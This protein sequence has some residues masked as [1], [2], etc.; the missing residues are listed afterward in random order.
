MDLLELV[1]MWLATGFTC[2]PRMEVQVLLVWKLRLSQTLLYRDDRALKAI[3][4]LK[5]PGIQDQ[6]EANCCSFPFRLSSN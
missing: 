5:Q 4:I 3:D 1:P 6:A 2:C